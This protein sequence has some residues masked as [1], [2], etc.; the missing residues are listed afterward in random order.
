MLAVWYTKTT[1]VSDATQTTPKT[2]HAIFDND[3][4]FQSDLDKAE[5]TE[6][7]AQII[8]KATELPLEPKELSYWLKLRVH[9]LL[10]QE[11]EV[12]RP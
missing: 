6:L 5:F 9:G 11:A 8:S 7:R 1:A 4:I 12:H 3:P 10:G 2:F